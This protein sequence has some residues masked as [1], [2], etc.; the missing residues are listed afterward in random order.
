MVNPAIRS[1]P[2][3]APRV[4]YPNDESDSE[5]YADYFASTSNA[6]PSRAARRVQTYRESSSDDATDS[7]ASDEE[8][9]SESELG[10][11]PVRVPAV[12]VQ[13]R[14]RKVSRPLRS[15]LTNS[16]KANKRQKTLPLHNGTKSSLPKSVT[17]P[18][19]NARIPPWQTLPYH[20]LLS[21]MQYAAYPLYGPS[22]RIQPSI[23]WLCATGNLCQSFHDACVAALVYSPPL[24]PSDRAHGLIRLLRREKSRPGTLSTSYAAK[25]RY[26]DI[27][28]KQLLTKKSGIA[29]EDLISLTPQLQGL[30][31]YSNYDDMTTVIWAQPQA[32]KVRWT[33]P[34]DLPD[35][36]EGDNLTM[37]SF[38]WNGRFPTAVDVLKE[39]MIAHSRPSFNKLRQ[40][41][42]LNLTLSE[43]PEQ[44]D[45]DSAQTSLAVALMSL[46]ELQ[47]LSFR[48]CAMFDKVSWPSLPSGLLQLEIT[49]CPHL[50]SDTLEGSL[51]AIG[52]S[53]ETL[54]LDGNQSMDLGFMANLKTTCPRLQHL[55]IDMLYI[56]PSSYR[57]R[58]PLFDELLPNGPPTWPSQLITVHIENMRQLTQADAEAFFASLVASSEQLP[59]LK[60][61]NLKVILKDVSW[62]DRAMLRKK[63]FRELEDVFLNTDKPSNMTIKSKRSSASKR[64]SSRIANNHLKK[65]SA[66]ENSDDS[67]VPVSKTIQARCDIV[68]LVISDQRP[69]ETQYRENDFLDSE[70]SDDEEYRD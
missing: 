25:I 22:S 13:T 3:R 53:L 20:V 45:I 26:L 50:T 65:L 23:N 19:T 39:A 38:E 10:S 28:V 11:T 62:R 49:N 5:D 33:Y 44:A 56:D 6:R 14:K 35:R 32:R 18:S 31:L 17:L 15:S 70:P 48:N 57:D 1:R 9:E 2:R 51:A 7:S 24:Y 27:E 41:S 43:K 42:F 21:I 34:S 40:V 55:Q 52:S 4:T 36:L 47:S 64:Q 69:A 46:P 63:W 16:F 60:N 54:T 30:R 66:S 29:L 59:H 8:S 67:D 12:V 58:D 61:L 68:E 37:R